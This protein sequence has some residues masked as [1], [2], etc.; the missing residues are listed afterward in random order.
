MAFPLNVLGYALEPIYL[1]LLRDR[2]VIT[3]SESTKSDL[4]RYGFKP[5]NVSIVSEGI[6]I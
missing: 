4:L 2:K 1:W 6:E 3:I 5:G